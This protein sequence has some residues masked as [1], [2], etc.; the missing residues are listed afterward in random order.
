MQMLGFLGF[1][2]RQQQR[3]LASAFIGEVTATLEAIEGYDEV[4]RLE[5]GDGDAES[6]LTELSAFR[7]P[8]SAFAD[9]QFQHRQAR[10][11]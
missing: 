2:R 3:N 9:L 7:L 8:P 10:Y 4:R 1:R 6:H 11:F 5:D